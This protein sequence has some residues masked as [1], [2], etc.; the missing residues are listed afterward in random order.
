MQ[1]NKGSLIFLRENKETK[2]TTTMTS[3]GL[4]TQVRSSDEQRFVKVIL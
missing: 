3:T 4:S 1:F 2:K